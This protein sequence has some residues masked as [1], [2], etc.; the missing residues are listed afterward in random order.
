MQFEAQH[1]QKIFL[2]FFLPFFPIKVL[3]N[4]F[5]L[6]KSN[7]DIYFESD[8]S[9]SH[10]E[11]RRYDDILKRSDIDAVDLV[12][13]IDSMPE[14]I[15]KALTSGKHVISEKP[16]APSIEIGR[17][18]LEKY[19]KVHQKAHPGL[20]WSV[21][22]QLWYEPGWITIMDYRK[23]GWTSSSSSVES[24]VASNASTESSSPHHL[25]VIGTP[26]VA[27]LTRVSA[28][29]QT[30]KYYATKWRSVPNYQGGYL[31][32]GGVHEICKLRMMFGEVEEV[33]AFTHQFKQ[34]LPPA[35]TL[36]CSLR[37]KSGVL[38]TFTYTF[39]SSSPTIA[40]ATVPHDIMITGSSG[41]IHAKNNEIVLNF[42]DSA[43]EVQRHVTSIENELG[44]L[45]IR[46]EIESFALAALGDNHTNGFAMYTPEQALQD[47]A[48]I[49]ALLESA[50]SGKC[51]TVESIKQN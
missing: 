5:F 44:Q 19:R 9:G 18:L 27:T 40:L 46:R 1:C 31:L 33:T 7:V 32:D 36:T 21:A 35:D 23:A 20:I 39:T 22:E 38:C 30:N 47:V 13:T 2:L 4:V 49:Q 16:M 42:T 43:G 45:S 10:V 37:F 29:N 3:S 41:S 48:V 26:L 14:F 34:D 24:Q 8:E 51:V 50:K 6:I 28:M 12:I 11:G 15:E 17:Q 25:S